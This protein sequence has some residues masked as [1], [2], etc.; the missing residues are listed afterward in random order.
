MHIYILH[1]KKDYE[2]FHFQENMAFIELSV[3]ICMQNFM[4]RLLS[5]QSFV[6]EML[7]AF[8]SAAYIQ[9]HF[10]LYFIMETNTM[11]PDPIAPLGTGP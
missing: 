6:P 5:R 4:H 3:I 8:M 2:F 7:N 11:N 1:D 10:R 9:A